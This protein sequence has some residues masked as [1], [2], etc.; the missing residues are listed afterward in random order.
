[1]LRR[2]LLCTV[3]R[4]EAF[5]S[6]LSIPCD[7][8]L[9]HTHEE[10]SKSSGRWRLLSLKSPIRGYSM[11]LS[12]PP[13][14]R[15]FCRRHRRW[16]AGIPPPAK[17]GIRCSAKAGKR[18]KGIHAPQLDTYRRRS[19]GPT[20]FRVILSDGVAP[21]ARLQ[22]RAC[23]VNGTRLLSARILGM[24]TPLGAGTITFRG[25]GRC[26]LSTRSDETSLAF[27]AYTSLLPPRSVRT[28]SARQ[29]I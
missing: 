7:R 22:N 19:E 21:A 4:Q 2:Y 10:C 9:I 28:P 6:G 23:H 16:E 5:I 1:M 17:G 24:D 25:Y 3:Q 26:V 13:A 11:R 18:G 27:W 20:A 8:W 15:H 29:P 14:V 12:P